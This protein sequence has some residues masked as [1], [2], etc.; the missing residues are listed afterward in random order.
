VVSRGKRREDGSLGPL[1]VN[2]G[3]HIL[4][5][6]YTGSVSK[7]AG[8]EYWIVREDEVLCVWEGSKQPATKIA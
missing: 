5:S 6:K 4:Y 1:D 7:L 3:D 8:E 2:V